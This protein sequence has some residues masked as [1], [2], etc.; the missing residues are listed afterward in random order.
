LREWDIALNRFLKTIKKTHSLLV[1]PDNNIVQDINPDDL[2][3]FH[4]PF[5]QADIL[6][7]FISLY[8][9]G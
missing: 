4:Q 6:L 8:N 7:G 2:S 1:I 9:P 5:R 3:G